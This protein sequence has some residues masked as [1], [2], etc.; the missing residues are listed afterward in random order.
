MKYNKKKRTIKYFGK[1]SY[2]KFDVDVNPPKKRQSGIKKKSS[3]K[4]FPVAM[5]I[6]PGCYLHLRAHF[7]HT[8]EF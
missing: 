2:C 5:Y 6:I 7:D 3:L 8:N 4:L 1:G